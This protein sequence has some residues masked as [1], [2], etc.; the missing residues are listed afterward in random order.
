MA[1]CYLSWAAGLFVEPAP[2]PVLAN[3]GLN[4]LAFM[5]PVYAGDEIKVRLTVRRKKRRTEDYGEVGWDVEITNQKDEICARY[6]LL[7]MVAFDNPYA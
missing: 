4:N 7:T 5:T 2:G 3:T 1:I 6:E